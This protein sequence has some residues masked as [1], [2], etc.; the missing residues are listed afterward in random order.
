MKI[1]T[2]ENI[3]F[4]HGF[5]FFLIGIISFST[6]KSHKYETVAHLLKCNYSK[7]TLKLLCLFS[8][9]IYKIH[10]SSFSVILH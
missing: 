3:N 7:R 2:K 10:C 8:F 9:Y 4:L 6:D 5:A 1:K